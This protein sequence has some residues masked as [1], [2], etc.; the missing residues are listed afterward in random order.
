M[1]VVRPT[2]VDSLETVK[3]CSNFKMVTLFSS[4]L[5]FFPIG[6]C[7]MISFYRIHNRSCVIGVT[8]S[9]LFVRNNKTEQLRRLVA[10]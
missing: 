6:G 3:Y 1:F 10:V 4:I 8:R 2:L 9:S 5:S 7:G